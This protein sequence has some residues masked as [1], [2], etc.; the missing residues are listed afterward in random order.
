MA[1]YFNEIENFLKNIQSNENFY[2][3]KEDI[4][5]L[6]NKTISIY[7]NFILVNEKLKNLF[8]EN[9]EIDNII[10]EKVKYINGDNKIFIINENQ[11][12]LLLGNISNNENIFKLEYIFEYN[13]LIKLSNN[14]NQIFNNYQKYIQKHTIFNSKIDNIY[15]S[16]IFENENLIIG[17]LYKYKDKIN[18]NLFK[19]N[20]KIIDIILLCINDNKLQN[21]LSENKTNCG[22][23]YL[24]NS[25]WLNKYKTLYNYDKIEKELLNN[26]KIIN[27]D[28]NLKAL[29]SFLIINHINDINCE[30]N[31][32]NI[33]QN[34]IE[35]EIN[36]NDIEITPLNYYNNELQLKQLMIYNNFGI[37]DQ[38]IIKFLSFVKYDENT[39]F[40]FNIISGYLIVHFP[41][42]QNEQYISLLG[43]LNYKNIFITK[44]IL[45]YNKKSDRES[46][47]I[48]L[49]HNLNNYLENLEL[50][51]NSCPITIKNYNI[52]GTIIKF[53][54]EN[55]NSSIN[56]NIN[57]NNNI[58][59]NNIN[60]NDNNNDY[61]NNN[62][63]DN[64]RNNF[65]LGCPHIGLTNI[66]AT[67]YMNSTLQC[68]CHIEKLVNY[69]K[70][71]YNENKSNNL[72][73]SFKILIESLWPNHKSY[74]F[75]APEEFKNKISK[76]NPLFEGIAA[77]DSKDLVNFIIMTLHEELN[78]ANKS[79]I[80]N[81]N[82][83]VDQKNKNLVFQSFVNSSISQNCSI[84]S[85][86][87]YG[88]NCNITDC[89]CGSKIYNY[90]IYFFII[91]PLEEVR[92]YKIQSEFNYNYNYNY[93]NM[94]NTV[95]IYDC[96][97]YDRKVNFMTGENSMYCNYCK[98]ISNCCMYTNLVTGPEILILLL[99]RGKGI[100]FNVKIIFEE[101]LN[102]ENYIEYKNAGYQYKLMGVITHI[103]E[104]SMS[105]H[106]IA[107]CL[108]PITSKWY[109]Y[110]DAIVNEVTNF[111]NEVINFAMPYL[112]FYQK[113][114]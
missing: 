57:K 67:C 9:F 23:I 98:K 80:N 114:I 3:E 39:F 94:I 11:N 32:Q 15:I 43:I 18:Y 58:I 8:I 81:N 107:Y 106:F 47:I 75:Y 99:N 65:K 79:Q 77:N 87:F 100:E 96:F 46:H 95:N 21:N 113:F 60:N 76:M 66:G 24:A 4:F 40:D 5:I 12:S 53:E 97:N 69:F 73:S 38:K 20:E 63:Y 37:L 110:N 112:L 7:N 33:N 85:D 105:G 17:N 14:L 55:A 19:I 36:I 1:P 6:N 44:Y 74:N 91:F 68:F 103:G 108:D 101:Y 16:P 83:I 25:D 45:I 35:I 82:V 90:Q 29:Y 89:N 56:N 64:I 93:N 52:I 41:S 49:K 84:I 59:N 109:K 111:Q 30:L 104:S 48:I 88:I 78:K 72:S 27:K 50:Y 2:S 13:E 70:Y 102:L 62:S 22:K 26:K 92:K 42:N 31:K 71:N 86:L 61:I 28:F 54:K 51:N 34:E 10:F